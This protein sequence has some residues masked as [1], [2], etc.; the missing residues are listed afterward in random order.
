MHT[1]LLITMVK[2]EKRLLNGVLPN[3]SN[4]H[5]KNN[6]LIIMTNFVTP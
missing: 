2:E 3:V 1:V 4:N 5:D 6:S